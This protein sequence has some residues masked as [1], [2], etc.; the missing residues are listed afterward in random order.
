MTCRMDAFTPGDDA[1][2]HTGK[3]AVLIAL[4]PD[5]I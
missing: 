1:K 3:N 4:K 2:D 5:K